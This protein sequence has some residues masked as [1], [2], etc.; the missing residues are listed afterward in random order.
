MARSRGGFKVDTYFI[1]EGN[2]EED[3]KLDVSTGAFS[4]FLS[5]YGGQSFK[6]KTLEGLKRKVDAFLLTG[7]KASWE[8]VAILTFDPQGDRYRDPVGFSFHRVFRAKA[9]DR[10]LWKKWG[11]DGKPGEDD[12]HYLDEND[13]VVPYTEKLWRNLNVL[14][15]IPL[16]ALREKGRAVFQSKHPEEVR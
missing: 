5:E 16:A 14:F 6:D 15:T 9:G 8:P 13:R 2:Y 11:D 12:H 10:E 4:L 7:G 3:I 1:K